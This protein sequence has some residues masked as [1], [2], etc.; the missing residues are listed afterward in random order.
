MYKV[1]I[2]DHKIIKNTVCRL[3]EKGKIIGSIV[4]E[5]KINIHVNY[6]TNFI[7]II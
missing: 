2:I 6:Q 3:I 5:E 4:N 1:V 7:S